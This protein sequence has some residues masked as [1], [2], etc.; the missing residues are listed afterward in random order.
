MKLDI[1]DVPKEELLLWEVWFNGVKINSAVAAD[2][3]TGEMWLL[4]PDGNN[5]IVLDSES[6]W[7]VRVRKYEGIVKLIRKPGWQKPELPPVEQLP[8]VEEWEPPLVAP[9]WE[10]YGHDS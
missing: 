8:A 6:P 9:G 3:E 5:R 4:H 1:R 7:K 2:E 10:S